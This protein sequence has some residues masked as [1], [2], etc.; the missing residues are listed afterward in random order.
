[1]PAAKKSDGKTRVGRNS[2]GMLKAK[3]KDNGILKKRN[4]K[5]K[6]RSTI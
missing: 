2:R 5:S 1:L 4:G 6:K 3:L